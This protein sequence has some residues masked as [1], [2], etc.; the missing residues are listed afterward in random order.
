M[1]NRD[2]RD[3]RR[4]YE[5]ATLNHEQLHLDPFMQFSEWMDQAYQQ[6]IKDPTAMSLATAGNDGQPHNR[7]VLLKGFSANGFIFYTHYDSD[8][9]HEIAENNKAAL[10]FFWPE[11]DRQIRIEG[12]LNKI[13]VDASDTYFQSRPRDS[14][15]AAYVSKQ[16]QPV[17][18]RKT[19]EQNMLLA[20][21]ELSGLPVPRPENWGGYS[22]TP[23]L[24]EFWQGR[25][26][27]LHDRFRYFNSDNNQSWQITRLSP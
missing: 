16:S 14:Q 10:L 18:G 13:P 9:G 24:F 27:R 25:P 3:E 26:N 17:P 12:H 2:Y 15:L 8:K 20:S 19:L 5:F 7:I 11:M 21:D 22:L 23:A 4:E 1:P 6:D